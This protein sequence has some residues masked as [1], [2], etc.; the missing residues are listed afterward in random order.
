MIPADLVDD[1]MVE[2]QQGVVR[3]PRNKEVGVIK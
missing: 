2:W 3:T 1:A